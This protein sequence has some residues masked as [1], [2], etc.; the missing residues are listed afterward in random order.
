MIPALPVARLLPHAGAM[1][2]I[3]EIVYADPMRIECRT[4]AHRRAGWKDLRVRS[5]RVRGQ[6]TRRETGVARRPIAQH[7][8]V[9]IRRLGRIYRGGRI[10]GFGV[11]SRRQRV[12]L[13]AKS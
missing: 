6:E 7:S 3:D 13:Q 2:L 10:Q 12:V 8:R 1:V 4:Q 9:G 11:R 5:W